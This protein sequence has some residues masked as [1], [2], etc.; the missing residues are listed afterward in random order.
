MFGSALMDSTKTDNNPVERNV[1]MFPHTTK[2]KWHNKS[3]CEYEWS[4]RPAYRCNA[5]SRV[6]SDRK[7]AFTSDWHG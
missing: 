2:L 5:S 6:Y 4:Y 1:N 7:P 3:G